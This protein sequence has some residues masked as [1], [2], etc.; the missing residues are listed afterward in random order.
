MTPP[1][2]LRRALAVWPEAE[3]VREGDR[4]LTFR[5]L[6]AEACRIAEEMQEAGVRPG[7]VVAFTAVPGLDSILTLLGVWE[8]GGTAFP[9][10]H[11]LA[12][13]EARRSLEATAPHWWLVEE[14]GDRWVERASGRGRAATDPAEEPTAAWILTSGSTGVPRAV[15]LSHGNLEAVNRASAE[16]LGL[17]AGQRWLASLSL[18]HVGGLALVHRALLTG[19]ALEVLPAFD[20]GTLL[21]LA[22]SGRVTHASLVPTMLLQ[23]VEALEGAVGSPALES[24]RCLLVGGAACPAELFARARALG[25][26][27]ALTYGLT[28]ASSQVATA[29]PGESS[30][31][32]VGPPLDGVE[33]R[34]GDD[35]EILVRGPTVA[36]GYVQVGGGA[37]P[38]FDPSPATP[39]AARLQPVTDPDGWL[40]TGDRGR[41]DSRGWLHVLGRKDRRIVSGGVNVEPAEVE[42]FLRSLD[43]VR[44]AVVVGLPDPRWGQTVAALVQGSGSGN[45]TEAWIR[46]RCAEGLQPAKRPRVIRVRDQVP[47]NPNGK[48]D[49]PRIVEFLTASVEGGSSR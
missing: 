23:V 26:P 46:T 45:P 31:G 48:P 37:E 34:V 42:D 29:Y 18:G 36:L 20:A 44:D 5:Q 1:T 12:P 7:E 21:G 27:V 40:H 15:A 39:G 33:V 43:G 35:D 13:G 9:L 3:A 10:S 6:H 8:L 28:Q 11:R 19:S 25:L 47:L 41:L 16:R 2:V 49:L 22:G 32:G 24:L 38:G 30:D 14:G 17:E 4:R